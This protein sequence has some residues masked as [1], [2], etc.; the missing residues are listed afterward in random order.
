MD[1]SWHMMN[2]RE[3]TTLKPIVLLHYKYT[4]VYQM[5]GLKL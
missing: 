2:Y 1:I 3:N 4:Q 5:T